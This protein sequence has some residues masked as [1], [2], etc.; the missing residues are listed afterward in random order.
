[1]RRIRVLVAD[2][3]ASVR[4]MLAEVLAAHPAIEVAGAAATGAIALAKIPQLR[5]DVVA[6]GGGLPDRDGLDLLAELRARHPGL[7]ALTF[8]TPATSGE[9]RAELLPRVLAAGAPAVRRGAA[10]IGVLAVGASAG[11]TDALAALFAEIPARFPVPVVIVLHMPPLFTR[12]FADRM[13][14]SCPLPFLEARHGEA[15]RA[16]RVHLAP[17]GAHLV[18][19][20][21]RGGATLAILN[22]PPEN[23]CRPSV[24]VLF[25]SV[26][27]AFGGAALAVVLTGM[28]QDGLRGCEALRERGAQILV[29][30]EASSVVWGMPGFVARAGLA[31]AV[32]PLPALAAEIARRVGRREAHDD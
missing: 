5:P 21:G 17:G 3:P 20:R 30:D 27:A 14:A 19:R 31:D 6:I 4:R 29:Q 24:D 12:Q 32:L 28:G 25:R 9:A 15:L 16:G 2:D 18:V 7:P 26:A 22:D 10:R 1:M 11:G 23:S 8:R 13:S